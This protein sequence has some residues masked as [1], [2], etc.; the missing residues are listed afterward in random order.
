L[1]VN[2]EN[3]VPLLEQALGRHFISPEVYG[4]SQVEATVNTLEVASISGTAF[5]LA[6][7]ATLY[8]AWQAS[9]VQPAEA[10]R[11]E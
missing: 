5:V 11:Y 9:K 1:A 3:I 6:L 8:P 10:L 2:V 7:L 4:I